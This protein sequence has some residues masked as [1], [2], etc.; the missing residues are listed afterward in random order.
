ML[1]NKENFNRELKTIKDTGLFKEERI[2]L[3]PQRPLI[4]VKNC[5]DVINFCSNNYL[6]LADNSE[7]IESARA[8]LDKY[9]LGL[10][11]VRFIC[12][13]QDIHKA[14]EKSISKFLKTDDTILYTSCYVSNCGLFEALLGADDAV[15]SD[16]LNHASIIDGI[17]LCKARRYRYMHNDMAD[18]EKC[19]INADRDGA[20]TKMIA[21][22]GVFS[23]E[24]SISKLDQ[25][26][27]LAEKYNALIMI[28]DCHGTGVI[29]KKGRGTHEYH[30]VMDKVDIITST[31]G[32]SLG[33]ASGGFTS[34]RAEII[35]LLRQKS[36]PYLYSN[37]LTPALAN[38][39]LK[40]IEIISKSSRL[41]QQLDT[42]T[43]Y[44]RNE[45]T[46]IGF[47]IKPGIHPIVPIMLY[48]AKLSQ[49]IS[50][51]LL[52]EGIYVIGS[53]YPIVPKGTA[54]IRVQISAAHTE[55]HLKKAIESFLKVGKKYR[56]IQ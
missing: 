20:D 16:Q 22:D 35:K 55:E 52:L 31:L 9:G 27:D 53:F 23:M 14:L 6:G 17:R 8:G 51:D 54:R 34:G 3:S 33:G 19:L 12:G 13:T 37:T 21:T 47:D 49:S 29:G 11:S 15:I 28:D 32:K 43:K 38:T 44:F 4:K 24:G 42:N 46:K 41:K 48:D 5:N 18:L 26:C 10:S 2:I 30:K 56:V 40:A 7:L 36:R 1:Y 25:I 50:K 45:M 39:A